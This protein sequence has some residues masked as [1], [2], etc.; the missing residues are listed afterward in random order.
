VFFGFL[1]GLISTSE[2]SLISTMIDRAAPGT[3]VTLL[4]RTMNYQFI[5]TVQT[6]MTAGQIIEMNAR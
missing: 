1:E 6:V 2:E 4:L 5:N 3:G